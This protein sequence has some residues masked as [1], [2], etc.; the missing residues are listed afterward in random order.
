MVLGYI[1]KVKDP[2][3][4]VWRVFWRVLV[5]YFYSKYVSTREKGTENAMRNDRKE[6][7]SQQ[8]GTDA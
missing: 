5:I 8:R 4:F 2:A 3:P 6:E 7:G 1:E